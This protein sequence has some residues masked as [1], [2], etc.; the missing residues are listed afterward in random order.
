MCS[1]VSF[2]K[3]RGVCA[4]VVALAVSACSGEAPSCPFT[5]VADTAPSAGCFVASGQELLLVQGFNGKLSPPGGSSVPGESAQC[6]AFRETWEETGLRLRPGELLEVFDTGFHLYRCDRDAHSGEIDPPVRF[7]IRD[8]FF[9]PV[10]RFDKFEWRYPEQQ[11]LLK[12]RLMDG[13][14]DQSP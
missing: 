5:G 8:A 14:G 11:L 2:A 4:V 13:A 9:L 6:T 3:F 7:E 1:P 10:A 12:A